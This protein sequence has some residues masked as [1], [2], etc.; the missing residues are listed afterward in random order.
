HGERLQQGFGDA[1]ENRVFQLEAHVLQDAFLPTEPRVDR[2]SEEEG[3]QNY[4]FEAK[5]LLSDPSIVREALE[6]ALV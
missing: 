1:F 6:R 4:T 3:E 5:S 2:P